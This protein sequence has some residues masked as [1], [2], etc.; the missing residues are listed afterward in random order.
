[1]STSISEAEQGPA[2]PNADEFLVERLSI[3]LLSA[4][5]LGCLI[6]DVEASRHFLGVRGRPGWLAG[7]T[8]RLSGASSNGF[9]PPE[10]DHSSYARTDR[11]G[12]RTFSNQ[13][14]AGFM[15]IVL[16]LEDS[17]VHRVGPLDWSIEGLRIG[18]AGALSVRAHAVLNGHRPVHINEVV[19]AFHQL[20]HEL[21]AERVSTLQRFSEVWSSVYPEFPMGAGNEERLREETYYYEIVDLDFGVGGAPMAPK[22]LYATGPIRALRQ[23]SG[24]T[25]MSLVWNSYDEAS[26]RRMGQFDLGSRHDEFWLVNEERLVRSHPDQG[27]NPYVDAFFDDVKLGTELVLQQTA[28]LNF[29]A[30]WLRSNRWR[31]LDGLLPGNPESAS[32]TRIRDTL[33]ELAGASDLFSDRVRVEDNSGHSFFRRLLNRTA[34]LFQL[35]ER[36]SDC[37][38]TFTDLFALA[39][40]A[41]TQSTNSTNFAIQRLGVEIAENSRRLTRNTLI[42]AGAAFFIAAVQLFVSL[43]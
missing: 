15:P 5:D 11:H 40:A 28:C 12:R 18:A 29:L 26:V 36:R 1:M 17:P 34:E 8:E 39:E 37:R 22:A 21:D 13:F 35:D 6:T 23:L 42:I 32:E 30:W 38:A 7:V 33:S 20:R 19:S 9:L 24:L 3:W 14:A 2:D 25:R 43:R 27:S 16:R 31:F 10:I 4:T 41:A